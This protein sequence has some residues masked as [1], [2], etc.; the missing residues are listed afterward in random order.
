MLYDRSEPLVPASGN[1]VWRIALMDRPTFVVATA[2]I[3]GIA[4]LVLINLVLDGMRAS[5]DDWET[6][7]ARLYGMVHIGAE[8]SLAESYNYGLAFGAGIMFLAA[9]ISS[10]SRTCLAMAGAMMIAWFDDSGQYHERMG[11]VFAESLPTLRFMALDAHTLGELFGW[12]TI[13]IVFAGLFLWA[14]RRFDRIDRIVVKLVKGP[15]LLLIAC[16][17]IVDLVHA[18][19]GGVLLSYLFL[20][21]EDGGEML[22]MALLAT[23]SLYLAR[24]VERIDDKP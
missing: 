14:S 10:R 12:L 24:N 13:G 4:A 2:L 6:V 5:P 1:S 23:A 17:S 16:A 11:T 9:G 21:L 3:G 19:A 15:L 22:A 7:P 18:L 8:R 20:Y